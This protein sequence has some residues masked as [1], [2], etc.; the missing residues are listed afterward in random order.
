MGQ[1]MNSRT[2]DENEAN[3]GREKQNPN[4][5]NWTFCTLPW[6]HPFSDFFNYFHFHPFSSIPKVLRY[7]TQVD[8]QR[9]M[10]IRKRNRRW[11]LLSSYFNLSP[12]TEISCKPMH[13]VFYIDNQ[14]IQAQSIEFYHKI[15]VVSKS[16][17]KAFSYWVRCHE[18]T[19]SP[20]RHRTY[21]VWPICSTCFWWKV[22]VVSPVP[23]KLAIVGSR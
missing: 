18:T 23:A 7:F 1:W 6:V 5:P 3:L 13:Q 9:K 16:L 10:D 21:C 15:K 22:Y 4:F 17:R 11:N 12:S 20:M 14:S 2:M 8:S 19:W